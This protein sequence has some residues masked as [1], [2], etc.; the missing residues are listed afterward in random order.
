MIMIKQSSDKIITLYHGSRD[1]I[2]TPE[3]GLGKK[4]NDFGQGFYCTESEELAKEWATTAGRD[5]YANRYLLDAEYLKI[6]NLNSPEYSVLNWIAVLIEHRLFTPASPVE[7][8]ARSYL[9]NNFS[10]KVNAYDIVTG[11]RADDSYYDFAAAFLSNTISIEQ[12]ASAMR[13]GKLGE[14]VVIKSKAAFASICFDG[15]IDAPAGIYF[16]NREAREKDA[17]DSYFRIL[18]EE[19]DGLYI[20]DIMRGKIDNDDPRIP[21]NICD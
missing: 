20:R 9:I 18:S 4:N 15:Y 14:Q 8:Q 10:V 13:L 16:T 19:S 17:S 11:Y 5:G 12:L 3:F 21:R 1:I 7:K 6:L 2:E